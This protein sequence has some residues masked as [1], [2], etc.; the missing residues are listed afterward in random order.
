MNYYGF[1]DGNAAAGDTTGTLGPQFTGYYFHIGE[2]GAAWQVGALKKPGKCGVG[3]WGQTGLLK[4]PS[5]GYDEGETGV[6]FFGSQRLWFRHPGVD[7]SGIS[8]FVQFGANDSNSSLVRQYFGCGLTAFSLINS[9]PRDTQGI[10]LAWA[11]LNNDP[12]AG[13]FF[14]PKVQDPVTQLRS[15]ELM[16]QGYYQAILTDALSF[17]PTLTY[18]PNPGVRENLDGAFALSMYLVGLF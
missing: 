3:V 10:G 2:V 13:T 7:N 17:Q 8:G 4:L 6:Y 16:L 9:R 18:I 11:W 5:G 12:N 14:Y 1:F 15:N